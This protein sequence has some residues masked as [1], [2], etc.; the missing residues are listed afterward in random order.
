MED[1]RKINETLARLAEVWKRHPE[2]R[3]GQLISGAMPDYLYYIED[4]PLVKAIEKTW[5]TAKEE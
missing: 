5:G 2:L 1:S 3:L 4:Q